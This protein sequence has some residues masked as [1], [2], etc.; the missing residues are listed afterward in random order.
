MRAHRSKGIQ[1]I[2]IVIFSVALAAP[3]ILKAQSKPP[4]VS[5]HELLRKTA[6]YLNSAANLDIEAVVEYDHFLTPSLQP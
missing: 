2:V 6:D 5:P 4:P 3:G 1:V